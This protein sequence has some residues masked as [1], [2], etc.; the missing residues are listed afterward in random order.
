MIWIIS[1]NLF[2]DGSILIIPSSSF[3]FLSIW[4]ICMIPFCQYCLWA[5]EEQCLLK[6]TI[7]SSGFFSLLYHCTFHKFL[8]EKRFSLHCDQQGSSPCNFFST[9]PTPT[10]TRPATPAYFC[11]WNAQYHPA[12]FAEGSPPEHSGR[13]CLFSHSIRHRQLMFQHL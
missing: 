5:K 13:F 11:L 8:H 12:A 1:L 6:I 4:H 3:H 2:H 7:S 9:H 10:I